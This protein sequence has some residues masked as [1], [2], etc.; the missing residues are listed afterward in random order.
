MKCYQI[1]FSKGSLG[2]VFRCVFW[3]K[4]KETVIHQN[5]KNKDTRDLS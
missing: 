1:N 4:I 3:K 2:Y 5:V